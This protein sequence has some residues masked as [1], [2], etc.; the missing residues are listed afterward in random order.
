MLHDVCLIVNNE[1]IAYCVRNDTRHVWFSSTRYLLII[2]TGSTVVTMK[3]TQYGG[4]WHDTVVCL[5][6]CLSVCN[7]LRVGVGCRGLKVVTCIVVFLFTDT[8]LL[9]VS[10]SRNCCA[11]I[12]QPQRTA[13]K[14]N[15]RNFCV[16]SSH[17]HRGHVTMAI[18]DA[19]FSSVRFCS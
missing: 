15:R 4:S 11:M 12:V 13:K 2:G 6:V 16:C 19:V 1:H 17:G 8:F 5:S 10:F 9:Q 14:P 18:P 3:C 7:A